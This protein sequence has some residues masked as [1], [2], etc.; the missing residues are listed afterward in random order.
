L[1]LAFP[2]GGNVFSLNE[3][4][5]RKKRKRGRTRREKEKEGTLQKHLRRILGEI[6][7]PPVRGDETCR[8]MG[9]ASGLPK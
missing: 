4:K 1:A 5:E 6:A 9:S 3:K 8:E 2:G 7:F